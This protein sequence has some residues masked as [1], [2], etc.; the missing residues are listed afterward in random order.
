MVKIGSARIDE[1]GK[2]SG[3]KAGDQTGLEVAIEPWYRHSKGWFVLRP[4]DPQIAERI[5]W[6]MEQACANNNI[7]YD[8]STSW[9][10]YDKSKW[11][12]WDCSKVTVPTETDCSSLIRVCIAYACQKSISWFSTLNEVE[13]LS[14]TGLFDV[15]T[16]SKYTES[17]DYLKR[18]DILCT[19]TQG[20]TVAV[21]DNGAMSGQSASSSAQTSL[22]GNTSLCGTGIGTAVALTSMYIRTG[23][24]TSAQK[25]DKIAAGVAVEVIEL[26]SSG[27]Y[28][29]V[30]PGASCGYA[31][32][33]AG[34][35]YYSYSPNTTVKTIAKG[36]RIQ[37]NGNKQYM[38]AWADTPVAAAP[39]SA[40]VTDVRINGKHQY[41]VVGDNVH[42]WVD[43]S[44]ITK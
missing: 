17:S 32:T 12:G 28:K 18:G 29:I 21:L 8:Q 9:D 40:T 42:G 16:D 3:G 6:D 13:V 35:G 34:N 11:Y 27:W 23:A 31:F 7:G 5:A 25:L 43:L 24:G 20:H 33:K 10:L 1:N 36:D 39:G 41:H 15:L 22:Q 38:S 14:K 19:R 30:W 37:Y 44:D 4:K 2:V 26:T